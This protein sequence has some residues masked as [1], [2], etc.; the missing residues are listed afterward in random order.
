MVKINIYRLCS[1][2]LQAR[3]I[4]YTQDYVFIEIKFEGQESDF[5]Q[6]TRDSFDGLDKWVEDNF[7]LVEKIV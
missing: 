4:R 7:Y 5:K 6:L 2:I 1:G 3:I